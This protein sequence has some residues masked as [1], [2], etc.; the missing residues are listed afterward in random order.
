MS[1][2]YVVREMTNADLEKLGVTPMSAEQMAAEQERRDRQIERIADRV[3]ERVA[4]RLAT[5]WK[6][7]F[8]FEDALHFATDVGSRHEATIQMVT[9]AGGKLARGWEHSAAFV[10]WWNALFPYADHVAGFACPATIDLPNGQRGAFIATW[11]GF[12][13]DRRGDA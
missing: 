4:S 5:G 1:K 8:A 3:R 6:L 9:L 13:A 2:G 7:D 11:S 10:R 12:L